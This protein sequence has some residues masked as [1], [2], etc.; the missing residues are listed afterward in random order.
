MDSCDFMQTQWGRQWSLNLVDTAK[1]FESTSAA[2]SGVG[3]GCN[4][5]Q[6]L[7]PPFI[8]SMHLSLIPAKNSCTWPNNSY[9]AF[10]TH[11]NVPKIYRGSKT[12]QKNAEAK[13]FYRYRGGFVKPSLELIVILLLKVSCWQWRVR[14]WGYLSQTLFLFWALMPTLLS[15][16][17]K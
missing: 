2:A 12:L 8:G 4:D 13:L 14:K 5:S 6:K 9:A 16:L 3:F 10:A 17:F 1:R 15:T 11:V 7:A